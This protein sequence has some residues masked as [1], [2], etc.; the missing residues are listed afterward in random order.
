VVSW[1]GEA[2]VLGR[3]TLVTSPLVARRASDAGALRDLLLASGLPD[4]EPL[5]IVKPT[6]HGRAPGT[7][8]DAVA[9]DLLLAALHPGTAL[10]VEGYTSGRNDGSR[11]VDWNADPRPHWDWIR[12]QD[13]LYL[14]QTGLAAVMERHGARY[15]SI[16]EEVW[17]GRVAPAGDVTALVRRTHGPLANPELAGLVPSLLYDLR[18]A[19]L[20]SLARFK[21]T[22]RL[23]TMNL[24]GLI[25]DVLRVRW[26]GEDDLGL[27]RS[28]VDLAM[29]Y[30][31]LFRLHGVVEAITAAVHWRE[32][33][34]HRSRWGRYD[35]VER[36]GVVVAGPNL[37]AVDAYCEL[38]QGYDPT[39][40]LY[41]W[42]LADAFGAWQLPAPEEIPV[43]LS[44]AL[45]P[46]GIA[47][48]ARLAAG[49][50]LRRPPGAHAHAVPY[51][52]D[53][54]DSQVP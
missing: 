11:A 24:F 37:G 49:Q 21:G 25:P 5:Y 46:E 20:I 47:P 41:L 6:W 7:F 19:P 2:R 51:G 10:V 26:H 17:S 44:A 33:G 40:C 42:V 53:G 29:L 28:M 4:H 54:T 13:R 45:D 31:S 12:A 32:T 48:A 34:A 50:R 38:L 8:T 27:M 14:E 22:M 35:L 1:A 43:E 36:P 15:L 23:A 16:T 9:L 30:G 39:Q 52:R 3:Q 18:G